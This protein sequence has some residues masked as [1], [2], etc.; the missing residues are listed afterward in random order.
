MTLHRQTFGDS[1]ARGVSRRRREAVSGHSL[2]DL[3]RAGRAVGIA[4]GLGCGEGPAWLPGREI[5]IFSD[6]PND[7]ILQYVAGVGTSVFREPSGYAN[8]NF[9]CRNGDV[10]TCEHLNRRITRTVGSTAPVVL[11]DH[12]DKGRLN[13]PNDVVEK[14]DGTIWFTDPTYGIA[15]GIEGRRAP[16]EQRCRNVF[17]LD[18]RDGTLT[19]QVRSLQ[20]PN[21]LCFSPDERI[22]YVADSGAERGGDLGFDPDGPR[23]VFAFSVADGVVSGESRHV[24]R[25]PEGVPDGIRCD[26]DGVLWVTMGSGVVLVGSSGERL[27]CL[28]TAEAVTN[29]CFGGAGGSEV[30]VTLATSAYLIDTAVAP[31]ASVANGPPSSGSCLS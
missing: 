25:V 23:D 28:R 18:P 16:S 21:G 24:L 6:I 2:I 17:R 10:V 8:G 20:M 29:L 9:V 13:S 15:G 27:G 5:W 26:E 30:L 1:L 31:W 22:L 11:C 7:R 14:S 3:V 12:F 4:E 19:S